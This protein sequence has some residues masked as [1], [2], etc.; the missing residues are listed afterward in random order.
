MANRSDAVEARAN[1]LADALWSTDSEAELPELPK[2]R[3]RHVPASSSRVS[4]ALAPQTPAQP[5]Q[6]QDEFGFWERES[7]RASADKDQ[8]FYKDMYRGD[9]EYP[10]LTRVER[11]EQCDALF[12]PPRVAQVR[13]FGRIMDPLRSVVATN[14]PAL[15]PTRSIVRG[16]ASLDGCEWAVVVDSVGRLYDIANEAVS[17]NIYFKF[18]I[19]R[20]PKHRWYDL[21]L[22]SSYD[23]MYV[24]FTANGRE[25]AALEK[26]AVESYRGTPRCDN[27]VDGGGSV[28]EASPHHFY[29]AT[30]RAG[31]SR[32]PTRVPRD[33]D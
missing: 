18:G 16:S 26:A 32:G 1:E 25:S 7:C 14:F 2:K 8:Q 21:K 30:R 10:K 3:A 29:I 15:D 6:D 4:P 24:F 12:N 27:S 20:D 9:Q 11:I 5:E 19:T 33:C 28:S 31:V 13:T 23:Q 17:R 22:N